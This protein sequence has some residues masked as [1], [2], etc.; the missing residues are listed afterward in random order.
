MVIKDKW[1][2]MVTAEDEKDN[3]VAVFDT[4][5]EAQW[6]IS[7]FIRADFKAQFPDAP[8]AE[9]DFT[10]WRDD[11]GKTLFE[12]LEEGKLDVNDVHIQIY[13]C[14]ALNIKQIK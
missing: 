3:T 13:F 5:M 10:D 2:L 12:A 9:H 11:N 6:F 4:K 7:R 1:L 8:S 14:S